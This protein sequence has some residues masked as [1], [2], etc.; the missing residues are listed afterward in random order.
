MRQ[1]YSIIVVVQDSKIVHENRFS[2][3]NELR[4]QRLLE[5]E[6]DFVETF[7]DD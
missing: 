6:N 1:T 5:I 4:I 3:N 7:L 2:K